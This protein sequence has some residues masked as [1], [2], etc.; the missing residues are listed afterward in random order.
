MIKRCETCG[1]LVK[2]HTERTTQFYTPL[3]ASEEILKLRAENSKLREQYDKLVDACVNNVGSWLSA[4]LDDPMVCKEMKA[5]V[6]K[7]FDAL[8]LP[9]GDDGAL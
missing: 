8:P 6:R 3:T 7:W 1:S 5:D 4:S 9:E 2:H